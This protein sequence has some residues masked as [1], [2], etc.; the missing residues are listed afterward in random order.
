[1]IQE[2]M[3][4][5]MSIDLVNTDL[6]MPKK[7]GLRFCRDMR[8]MGMDLTVLGITGYMVP[9]VMR[10][11]VEMGC[12]DCLEKPFTPTELVEKVEMLLAPEGDPGNERYGAPG[13]CHEC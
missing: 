3:E 2:N 7:D 10:E 5:T 4:P 6:V 11:L 12:N 13:R 9:E 1:M 8:K